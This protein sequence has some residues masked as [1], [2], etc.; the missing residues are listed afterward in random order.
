MCAMQEHDNSR[1][2][3]VDDKYKNFN[4]NS[5]SKRKGSP[6]NNEFIKDS[7]KNDYLY[8]KPIWI[9]FQ[10]LCKMLNVKFY[11]TYE[12]FLEIKLSWDI[13]Y[14]DI[15]A[16]KFEITTYENLMAY[17]N[18]KLMVNDNPLI[19]GKHHYYK[20]IID[21][22][23]DYQNK[24]QLFMENSGSY[25]HRL[26]KYKESR[27]C[28]NMP[29]LIYELD[30]YLSRFY[31]S[32]DPESENTKYREQWIILSRYVCDFIDDMEAFHRQHDMPWV[33]PIFD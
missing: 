5:N 18:G 14:N 12:I 25:L 15:L 23:Q 19:I 29:G 16:D 10:Q 3:P 13:V 21:K 8:R 20:Y 1:Y 28:F 32:D 11:A 33:N 2:T 30:D 27:K 22:L 4:K 17:L 31:V 24:Y 9:S 6:R 26:K 7:R